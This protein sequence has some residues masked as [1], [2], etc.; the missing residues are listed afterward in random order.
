MFKRIVLATLK[1]LLFAIL[2]VLVFL[3]GKNFD[4]LLYHNDDREI[5]EKITVSA[6]RMIVK[7][8]GKDRALRVL[9]GRKADYFYDGD[10]YCV[11]YIPNR[12]AIGWVLVY[13][14]NMRGEE[15][16]SKY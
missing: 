1:A 11:R 6:K 7:E 8:Y 14:T 3:A 2:L 16:F 15:R 5:E 4:R 13:C 12:R 10:E 9:E